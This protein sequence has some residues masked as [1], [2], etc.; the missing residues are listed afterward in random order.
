MFAKRFAD[1]PKSYVA[2]ADGSIDAC[3]TILPVPFVLNDKSVF[4]AFVVI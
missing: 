1:D 2:F 3:T 4:E